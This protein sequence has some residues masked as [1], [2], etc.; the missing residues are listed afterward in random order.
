MARWQPDARGRWEAA[1]LELLGERGFDRTTA[2]DI[3]ARAGLN[4]R[5]F[6]DRLELVRVRHS[7]IG[8]RPELQER[9]LRK[10]GSLAAAV[11]LTLRAKGS[12]KPRPSWPPSPVSRPSGLHTP[13]GSHPGSDASLEDHAA[14]PARI[15][16]ARRAGLTRLDA[17]HQNF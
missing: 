12:T 6:A 2:T 1:A 3:A 10:T 17:W 14:D 8:A 15:S 13:A 16:P 11:A 5:T 9:E 7:I 4:E